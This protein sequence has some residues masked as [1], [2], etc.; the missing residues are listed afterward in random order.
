MRRHVYSP[1]LVTVHLCLWTATLRKYARHDTQFDLDLKYFAS[2][3][4]FLFSKLSALPL[5]C[6]TIKNLKDFES[7]TLEVV[8]KSDRRIKV[9]FHR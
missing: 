7:F 8:I 5:L 1:S 2:F 4:C 6:R 9:E 3:F